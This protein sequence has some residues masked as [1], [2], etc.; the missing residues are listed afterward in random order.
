MS[1]QGIRKRTI[2]QIDCPYKDIVFVYEGPVPCSSGARLREFTCGNSAF[3]C[4][5]RG[6]NFCLFLLCYVNI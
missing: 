1:V 6:G 5:S 4:V 3:V 2:D